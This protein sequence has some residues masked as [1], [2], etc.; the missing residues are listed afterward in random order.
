MTQAAVPPAVWE[1]EAARGNL[2]EAL[3]AYVRE[4]DGVTFAELQHRFDPYMNV[5]GE[6][7]LGPR[8]DETIVYWLGMSPEFVALI[9]G[10]VNERRLFGDPATPWHYYL[11]GFSPRLPLAKRPPKGGYASPHWLPV[12]LSAQPWRPRRRGDQALR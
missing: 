2:A 5:W 12:C 1:R 4:H 6:M 3:V 11:A 10:L 7:D 8:D 9:C